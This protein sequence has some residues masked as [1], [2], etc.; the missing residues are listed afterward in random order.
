MSFVVPLWCSL[1][2]AAA[3]FVM[4]FLALK[5]AAAERRGGF[6]HA[7][8]CFLDL[9]AVRLAGGAGVESALAFARR[10]VTAGRSPSCAKHWERRGFMGEP[11]WAALDRLGSE[12]GISELN[13]L[14]ASV[15]LAGEEGA[16]VRAPVAAKA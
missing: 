6:R 11:P 9:V 16:R 12:I 13:E 4:P 7:F 1:A 8:S 5:T 10:A 2:L 15:A 14:A 3:G